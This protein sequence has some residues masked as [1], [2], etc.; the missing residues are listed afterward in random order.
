MLIEPKGFV[1]KFH[2]ILIVSG[3]IHGGYILPD[4]PDTVN[5]RQF[6]C[7]SCLFFH[8]VPAR[9]FLQN[10]LHSFGDICLHRLFVSFFRN[11]IGAVFVH[12][13]AGKK[14]NQTGSKHRKR[15]AV[16]FQ[17]HQIQEQHK[18]TVCQSRQ[19]VLPESRSLTLYADKGCGG[20]IR[21]NM[22]R[23]APLI[24]YPCGTFQFLYIPGNFQNHQGQKRNK[25]LVFY[26][27]P[28][29]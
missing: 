23:H 17:I 12:H 24:L 15:I 28:A 10:F 22:E 5:I 7:P 13:P 19:P 6:L 27:Q 29:V 18:R 3:R 4:I 9:V 20:Q 21:Q 8:A 14:Q 25:D 1:S 11:H 2:I 26:I 16:K